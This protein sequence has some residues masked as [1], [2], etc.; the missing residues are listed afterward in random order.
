MRDDDSVNFPY[1]NKFAFVKTASALSLTNW[2]NREPLCD[3]S[4][5]CKSHP[6]M[7][8]CV[9][10]K[11]L[12]TMM[13]L[14]K[15]YIKCQSFSPHQDNKHLPSS[16]L[17]SR[18]TLLMSLEHTSSDDETHTSL[19]RGKRKLCPCV[20]VHSRLM[21]NRF[22]ERRR[23]TLHEIKLASQTSSS[24]E[25]VKIRYDA[26]RL[27]RRRIRTYSSTN[28]VP[29]AAASALLVI[30]SFKIT[31]SRSFVSTN[32]NS[33]FKTTVKM[34]P[35]ATRTMHVNARSGFWCDHIA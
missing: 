12:E 8:T 31:H 21:T 17:K 11:F 2:K 27:R 35:T 20:F 3:S 9:V 4:P 25:K 24:T 18:R 32:C 7:N 15:E 30:P 19:R 29:S 26:R 33:S 34:H 28:L 1:A 23:N 10:V 14:C 6:R 13:L 22:F 5:R 16:S